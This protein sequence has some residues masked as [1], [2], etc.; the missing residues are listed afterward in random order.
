MFKKQFRK[1]IITPRPGQRTSSQFHL[2]N[3]LFDR[4]EHQNVHHIPYNLDLTSCDF[5]GVPSAVEV[6]VG[7]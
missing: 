5:L 6:E 1:M 3:Q 4:D 7:L 2:D